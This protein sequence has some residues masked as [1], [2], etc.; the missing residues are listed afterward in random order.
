MGKII[1]IIVIVALVYFLI[2]PKFTR[3]K[4]DIKEQ[5]GITDLVECTKC[6]TMVDIKDATISTSGYICSECIKRR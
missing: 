4:K 3:S 6:G 2:L 1:A 5:K